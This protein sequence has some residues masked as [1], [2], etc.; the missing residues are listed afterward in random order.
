MFIKLVTGYIVISTCLHAI[1]HATVKPE[2]LMSIFISPL[3][4]VHVHVINHAPTAGIHLLSNIYVHCI[5]TKMIKDVVVQLTY[6]LT[7]LVHTGT[8]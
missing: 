1:H 6:T 3:Q 5:T 4:T 2:I 7:I 8:V